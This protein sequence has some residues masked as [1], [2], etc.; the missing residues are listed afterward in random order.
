MT[1]SAIYAISEVPGR[2]AITDTYDYDAFGNEVHSAGTTPNNFLYRGDQ[3]DPDL[4]LYYLRARYYNPAT[5]RFM[6]RDPEMETSRPGHAAQV[7]LCQWRSRK[8]NRSDGTGGS[9]RVRSTVRQI[10]QSRSGIERVE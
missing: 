5:G 4:G 10:S 6:S 8:W 9:S 2:R 7:P 3:F 1:V